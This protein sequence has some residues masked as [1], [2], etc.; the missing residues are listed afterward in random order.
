MLEFTYPFGKSTAC[1]KIWISQFVIEVW[2]GE[3]TGY[4]IERMTSIYSPNPKGLPAMRII[5]SI[6]IFLDKTVN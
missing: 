1:G 3:N 2:K 4:V 6:T 5:E